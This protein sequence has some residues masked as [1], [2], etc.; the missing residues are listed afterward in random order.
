MDP[1]SK[2]GTRSGTEMRY[3]FKFSW[4]QKT[5][6]FFMR[7]KGLIQ[8]SETFRNMGRRHTLKVRKHA[9]EVWGPLPKVWCD[10]WFSRVSKHMEV[11]PESFSQ[12]GQVNTGKNS[13]N[14]CDF[15][16]AQEK[17]HRCL[18][19]KCVLHFHFQ[20]LTCIKF[21]DRKNLHKNMKM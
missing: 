7:R 12:H 15:M 11:S 10:E 4:K 1:M 19:V 13:G 3:Y 6:L 5:T 20:N 21:T 18:R 2:R 9:P 17:C 14:L 16:S 8:E